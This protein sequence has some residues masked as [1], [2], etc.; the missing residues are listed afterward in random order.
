MTQTQTIIEIP[1]AWDVRD[2]DGFLVATFS[3][4]AEAERY[5]REAAA[6]RRMEASL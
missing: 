5:V 6:I 1:R 3:T 2:Q 4:R